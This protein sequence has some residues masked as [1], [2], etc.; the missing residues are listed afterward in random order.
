MMPHYLKKGHIATFCDHKKMAWKFWQAV[1]EIWQ[2]VTTFLDHCKSGH[3][4]NTS[5]NTTR[6]QGRQKYFL[7]R[8]MSLSIQTIPDMA[9]GGG[10][11]CNPIPKQKCDKKNVV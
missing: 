8:E 7:G 4:L 6:I 1:P 10:Y 2:G 9:M 3:I 5:V 11:L